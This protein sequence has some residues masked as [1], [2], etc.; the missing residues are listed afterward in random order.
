MRKTNLKYM[1]IFSSYR[2]FKV[3]FLKASFFEAPWDR[4]FKAGIR[5]FALTKGYISY[6]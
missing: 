2:L 5:N 1:S 3:E 6:I 4:F